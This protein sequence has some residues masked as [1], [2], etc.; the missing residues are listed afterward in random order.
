MP[1]VLERD[2]AGRL[3]GQRENADVSPVLL[4]GADSVQRPLGDRSQNVVPDGFVSIRKSSPC[5]PAIGSNAVKRSWSWTGSVNT[6][7]ARGAE[8]Q[9]NWGWPS[10]NEARRASKWARLPKGATLNTSWGGPPDTATRIRR[11]SPARI[12]PSA[13]GQAR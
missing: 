4:V 2:F 6:Q 11:P 7:G 1:P 12:R 5:L 13:F 10:D 3:A 8:G 9:R